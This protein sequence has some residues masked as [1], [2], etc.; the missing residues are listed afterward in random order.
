MKHGLKL[1]GISLTG[2]TIAHDV[3]PTHKITFVF[4]SAARFTDEHLSRLH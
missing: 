3:F 4:A 2:V 1:V